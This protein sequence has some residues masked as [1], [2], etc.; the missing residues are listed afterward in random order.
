MMSL[1][2]PLTPPDCDLR[3]LPFMPMDVVRVLDSDLFA[4]STGEEFKAALALW[5]KAWLQVPAASLPDDDRVL[6]HLSGA[7]GRWRKLR[8]MALRGWIKCSDGRFYHPVVAEKATEAWKHRLAQRERAN[9][10][11]GN[12]EGQSSGTATAM[13]RHSHGNAS[14]TDAAMQGRGTGTVKG[15]AESKP[16]LSDSIPKPEP[17]RVHVHEKPPPGITDPHLAFEYVCRAA[18]WRAANDTQRQNGISII[19]GWLALGCTLELILSAIAKARKRDASPTKSLKRFDSTV[20]GMRLDQ[21]GGGLPV[22]S[23]D[24]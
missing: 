17:S 9:K 10:R 18:D 5:C 16:A 3:G 24:A 11:W 12:A 22:T 21:L 14:A 6:A 23:A 15:K 2:D 20:R 7:C 1:P 19:N 13:P 8:D 4:L